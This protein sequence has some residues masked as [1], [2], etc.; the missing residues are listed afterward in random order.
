L[1]KKLSNSKKQIEGTILL[2]TK[3][4]VANESKALELFNAEGNFNEKGHE[5]NTVISSTKS[6]FLSILKELFC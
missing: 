3:L 1:I 6:D 2:N 5:L 4:F